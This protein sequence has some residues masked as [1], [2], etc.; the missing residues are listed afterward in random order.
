M[1][2]IEFLKEY[3]VYED[4]TVYNSVGEIV[5]TV[6]QLMEEYAALSQ[7]HVMRNVLA[8]LRNQLERSRQ[9]THLFDEDEARWRDG[10]ES[11]L[12]TAIELLE[13]ALKKH[14]L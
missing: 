9:L 7:P 1:K 11:G 2:A 12:E 13:D 4:E 10:M 5:G 14:F 8:D 6:S 3:R